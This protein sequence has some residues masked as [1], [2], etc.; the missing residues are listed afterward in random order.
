MS[1]EG[2][3]G[4][5][6]GGVVA[7]FFS[8]TEVTD[9]NA[10]AAYNAWHQLDHLPE[11]MPLAGIAHGE[12]WVVSPR[13]RAARHFGSGDLA[14]AHYLTLYLMNPPLRESI[15]AFYDL[16]MRLH[17][18][19][20]FFPH[21]RAIATGALPVRGAHA[22]SRVHVSAAAVPYRPNR[23]VYA[24]IE[25]R[26][27][28]TDGGNDLGMTKEKVEE[29][30]SVPGVAGVWT[31]GRRPGA[32]GRGEDPQTPD[33]RPRG[34]DGSLDASVTICYLDED[35]VCVSQQIG[36]LLLPDWE[37]RRNAPEIAGPLE[38]I[39]PWSWDWFGEGIDRRP[40]ELRK[41]DA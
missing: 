13:C 6:S 18:E 41:G 20:R 19:D 30:L 38:A 39:I 8:L 24:V 32:A 10:H 15:D 40:E 31:F 37:R 36:D 17:R 22:A 33:S 12:R 35:P 7:G 34:S 4:T 9:P 29:L 21:R 11:Q 25:T 3:A 27:E 16:A 23:G 28:D 26:S 2:E 1:T 14:D 5:A